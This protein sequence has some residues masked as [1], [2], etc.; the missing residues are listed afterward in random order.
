MIAIATWGVVAIGACLLAGL[1]AWIKNRNASVWMG[2][3]FLLP[4][5][6]LVLAVLPAHKGAR[7]RQPTSD[8][9]D[10][11]ESAERP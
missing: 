1:L 4:P 6:V 8:E 11:I 3:S 2:W 5:L 10:H 9:I 7:P